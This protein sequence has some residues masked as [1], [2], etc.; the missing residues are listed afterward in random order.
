MSVLILTSFPLIRI[1][2]PT[3]DQRFNMLGALCT[4]TISLVKFT[5][6][7]PLLKVCLINKPHVSEAEGIAFSPDKLV[8]K[9]Y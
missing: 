3:P 5:L 2:L 7:Q 8:I 9:P 4:K 6:N 1:V